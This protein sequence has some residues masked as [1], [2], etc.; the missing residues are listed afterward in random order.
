MFY[1]FRSTTERLAVH[2]NHIKDSGD[3]VHSVHFTGGRDWIIVATKGE[4]D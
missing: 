3:A 2:L 1:T 4:D